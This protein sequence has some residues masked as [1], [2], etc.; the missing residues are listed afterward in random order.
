MRNYIALLLCFLL[1]LAAVPLQVSAYETDGDFIYEVYNEQA[2][3]LQYNGSDKVV[4]VP[5]ELGGYPVIRIETYA[6]R[7]SAV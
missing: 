1:L 4:E 6:F 2:S 5:G 7:E 3:L